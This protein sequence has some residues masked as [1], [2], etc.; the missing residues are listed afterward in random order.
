MYI[1]VD[2]F[3]TCMAELFVVQD[4]LI[5]CNCGNVTVAICDGISITV[6]NKKSI[7]FKMGSAVVGPASSSTLLCCTPFWHLEYKVFSA[8]IGCR[9]SSSNPKT[10]GYLS[11]TVSYLYYHC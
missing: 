8:V 11:N 5:A 7:T 10:K 9:S 6:N 1:F 3:Q 4:V 2:Q